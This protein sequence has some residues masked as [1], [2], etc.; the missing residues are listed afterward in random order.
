VYVHILA[1]RA[2]LS[3]ANRCRTFVSLQP[4]PLSEA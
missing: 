1:S 3:I 4:A 2:S